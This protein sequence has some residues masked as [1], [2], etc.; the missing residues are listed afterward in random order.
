MTS[1]R[2]RLLLVA[3]WAVAAVATGLVSAGAVAVA[4]GQVTDRPLRPLSAAEVAALPVTIEDP[5]VTSE[6]LASGGSASLATCLEP[7]SQS[8]PNAPG[9]ETA[10]PAEKELLPAEDPLLSPR[11][12]DVE[13]PEPTA[14]EL[15]TGVPPE[16]RPTDDIAAPE[17]VEVPRIG[18]RPTEPR[19]AELVGGRVSVSLVDGS[20]SLNAATPKAGFVADLRFERGDE[21]TVSF[22]DGAHLSTLEVAIEGAELVLTPTE[23]SPGA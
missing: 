7:G 17:D 5:C 16:V 4:G 8:G 14:E 11:T 2:Q 19:I 18:P 6:P 13:V 23:T 22:W 1:L 12:D 20:I 15:R 3:G 21:L 10:R 9:D